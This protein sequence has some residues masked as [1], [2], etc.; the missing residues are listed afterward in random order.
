MHFKEHNATIKGLKT[1]YIEAG[2][3][4]PL[5]FIHGWGA[6]SY[7][8]KEALTI[9]ASKYHVYALDLPGFGR[10]S[11]PSKIWNFGD[12]ADFVASFA[13]SVTRGPII[14][15]GHSLGGGIALYAATR[16]S[17]VKELLLIDAVGLP[18]EH[19]RIKLYYLYIQ[20]LLLEMAIPINW[21]KSLDLT[22]NFLQSMLHAPYLI[23]FTHKIFT[24]QA[25]TGSDVF[26]NVKTSVKILWGR[27]D[28]IFG[29]RVGEKL[30]KVL[31]GATLAYIEGSHNWIIFKPQEIKPFI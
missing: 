14:L 29:K 27:N 2:E 25:A 22:I 30:E 9:L 4:E 20:Q 31:P 26:K 12:Y 8:Y 15:A 23:P 18:I 19:N 5:I 17:S 6:R 28:T 11:S 13:S 1:F 16:I 10:S 21:V 3:G 7:S 24:R